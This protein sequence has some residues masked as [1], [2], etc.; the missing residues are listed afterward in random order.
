MV[1]FLDR[2]I[3]FRKVFISLSNNVVTDDL[4]RNV[5]LDHIWV[6]LCKPD[7]CIFGETVLFPSYVH[8]S[9]PFL[10]WSIE[11]YLWCINIYYP[12]GVSVGLFLFPPVLL[13]TTR[14]ETFDMV[15]PWEGDG[16]FFESSFFLIVIF[17]RH[18]E[19]PW[20]LVVD[21]LM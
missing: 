12:K 14:L 5:L 4:G 20:L 15:V 13:F 21:Y 8:V 6:S 1:V 2:V 10:V 17:V 19:E 9:D 11:M 3:R 16:M 18:F 7:L